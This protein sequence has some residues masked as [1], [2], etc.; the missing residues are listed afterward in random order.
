MKMLRHTCNTERKF[1]TFRI[2]QSVYQSLCLSAIAYFC[3][4]ALVCA[5]DTTKKPNVLFIAVDDLRPQ[6][7]CYGEKHMKTPN[8]DRFASQGRLFNRHYVQVPTC[9]ASRY[10]LLTG[11]RPTM[12][13]HI[14]NNA[15]RDQFPKTPKGQPESFAEFFKQSGYYTQS[16]GKISHWVDGRIYA[17]DGSGAGQLEMPRSWNDVGMPVGKWKTGWT[18]FFGYANGKGR[19]RGPTGK[20]KGISPAFEAAD[21]PDEGYPDGLIANAAVKALQENK[22]RPFLLAV[23]F[24]KP[25]L[26]FNA[27][28]KY[29]DMYDRDQIPLSPNPNPPANAAAG[30]VHKSG[31]MFGNY[32]HPSDARTHLEYHKDLRH[33]YFA[34]VSYIDAQIGK[35]LGELDRLGLADDTIVVIWGDH[36]WHLGDHTIWGKHSTFERSLRSTLIIRTPNIKSPGAKTNSIV[37]TVDLYPTLTEFCGLKSPTGLDG[38]SLLPILNDPSAKTKDAAYG[39]WKDR[40]TIRTNNYRMVHWPK[41]GNKSEQ[42]ELYEHPSDDNETKNVAETHPDVIERLLPKL[43]SVEY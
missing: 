3:S 12:P 15:I 37:E 42:F 40:F 33:A 5:A 14:S 10:A 38:T 28:K 20:G 35:V 18:S 24:F 19:D 32:K 4:T 8:F 6:L 36:G 1:V 21:V 34:C 27:P 41:R 23:G 17:Y 29:F 9:G 13:G 26:P 7:G 16:I 2:H 31:E 22:D 43:K 39:F 11:H 25:H 30:S